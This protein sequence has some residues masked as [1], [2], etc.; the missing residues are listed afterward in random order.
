MRIKTCKNL[1]IADNK[2]LKGTISNAKLYLLNISNCGL[3]NG[4][5]TINN[6]EIGFLNY[7]GNLDLDVKK[8]IDSS[9]S[10]FVSLHTD[11]MA[12]ELYENLYNNPDR[13]II[14]GSD[15]ILVAKH[16]VNEEDMIDL[17]FMPDIKN[18]F[19]KRDH[20]YK[21]KITNGVLK[22]NRYAVE[23]INI[24]KNSLKIDF[25]YEND[26]EIRFTEFGVAEETDQTEDID[27]IQYENNKNEANNTNTIDNVNNM[28]SISNVNNTN[29]TYNT[30]TTQNTNTINDNS[31]NEN[32]GYTEKVESTE[33]IQD[34]TGEWKI[35]S[36]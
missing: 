32:E 34:I 1:S 19:M 8:I 11:E 6:N 29:I 3:K 23:V 35:H 18:I 31:I 26:V 13:Y 5:L 27:T 20:F 33:K 22:K 14:I 25:E 17:S 4:D 30:N 12:Y 36:A 28:N 7:G 2:D 15:V 21:I 24:S 9:S 10:D 16:P